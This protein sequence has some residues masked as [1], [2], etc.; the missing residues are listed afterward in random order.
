MVSKASFTPTHH[1]EFWKHGCSLASTAPVYSINTHG[2]DK[3]DP[4]VWPVPN[5]ESRAG[6]YSMVLSSRVR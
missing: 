5:M 6:E 3:V 4:K 1:L 2:P